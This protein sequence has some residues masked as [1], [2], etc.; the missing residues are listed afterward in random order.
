MEKSLKPEW[1]KIDENELRKI[2]KDLADKY[3]PSVIGKILRDQH[4]VPSTKAVF[5]KPLSFYLKEIN[6]WENEDLQNAEK[7]LDNLQQHLKKHIQDKK[8]KHKLQKATARVNILR[9]YYKK[10]KSS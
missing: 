9:N 3:P 5:G 1:L 6:L 10:K 7:K 2:I 4:G 8:A